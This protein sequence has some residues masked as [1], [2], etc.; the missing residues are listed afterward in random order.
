MIKKWLL[1]PI[2]LLPPAL[3]LTSCASVS[4]FNP[5][6]KVNFKNTKIYV[7]NSDEPNKDIE[8]DLD[9]NFGVIFDGSQG[10]NL[11]KKEINSDNYKV[12]NPTN[13]KL[14][15]SLI[16]SVVHSM[17]LSTALVNL[18]H[19]PGIKDDV[20][21][22]FK[23]NLIFT[24]TSDETLLKEFLYASA[25]ILNQGKQNQIK[26]YL[27]QIDLN[28]SQNSS[29]PY[30]DVDNFNFKDDPIFLNF[31]SNE[32]TEL[33]VDKLSE[34]ITIDDKK[35]KIAIKKENGDI[36]FLTGENAKVDFSNIAY[37]NSK[38]VT[39][40]I[41]FIFSY[42]DPS[43]KDINRK[44][45]SDLEVIKN[46]VKNNNAWGNDVVPTKTSFKIRFNLSITFRPQFNFFPFLIVPSSLNELSESQK[47]SLLYVKEDSSKKNYTVKYD[48]NMLPNFGSKF[49]KLNNISLV[50]DIKKDNFLDVFLDSENNHENGEDFSNVSKLIAEIRN[51]PVSIYI[52]NSKDYDE[53]V[54]KIKYYKNTI[55]L[56]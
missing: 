37:L 51:L 17:N 31:K 13:E 15:F 39:Y 48:K 40:N 19:V 28:P 54:K 2:V 3:V 20:N 34:P 29:N 38:K 27:N 46:Y 24:N 18:A 30:G 9:N 12:V 41:D 1:L 35:Q 5:L 36:D 42:F 23:N 44:P 21:S 10:F 33:T 16:S 26:L 25:N 22:I 43:K 55:K 32:S 8:Q 4:Q 49:L 7:P 14:V 47:E 50:D 56:S 11:L 52:N 53:Y 45:I 6:I